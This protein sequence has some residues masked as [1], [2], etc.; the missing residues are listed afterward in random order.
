MTTHLLPTLTHERALHRDGHIHIAG[1]DEAGRGA[2][3][4]PVYAAAVILPLTAGCRRILR[5]V[6]DSKQLT[7]RQRA[8]YRLVIEQTALA[9]SI[10]SA[11]HLE[12]DTFGV[13]QATRMAMT[14]A[15]ACLCIS[16]DALVID[17][18]RLPDVAIEQ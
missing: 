11:S 6:N 15:I 14:R 16:P 2:W 4:G 12:V 18:V 10:G 9:C 7:P 5:G 8:E 17:A 13:V 3:A 1:V